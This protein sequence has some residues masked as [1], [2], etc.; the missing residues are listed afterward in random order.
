[1]VMSRGALP[2]IANPRR[3]VSELL[4]VCKP[5]GLLYFYTYR[6]GWYDVVLSGFRKI[7]QGLGVRF[8]SRPIYAVCRLARLDP[9]VATMILDELFVPIRNASSENTVVWWLHSSGIRV[10]SIRPIV[11]AQFGDVELPVDPRTA[12][13]HRVLPKN[14]IISLAVRTAES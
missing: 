9:R 1:M 8:C 14:G 2:A 10:A 11:H 7:A 3:A 4:R 13:L 6:H 12:W 5:G